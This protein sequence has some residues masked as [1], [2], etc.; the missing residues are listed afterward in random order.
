MS[1]IHK[2][3]D[4]SSEGSHI[5]TG[6]EYELRSLSKAFYITGNEIMGEQLHMMADDLRKASDLMSRALSGEINDRCREAQESM[7]NLISTVLE[8]STKQMKGVVDEST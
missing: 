7:G 2:N 1:N 3:I 5:A 4:A 8:V 6:I